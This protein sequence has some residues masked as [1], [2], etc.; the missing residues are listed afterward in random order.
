MSRAANYESERERWN[1]ASD[2]DSAQPLRCE[3]EC[4]R[5][6]LGMSRKSAGTR[7]VGFGVC[8]AGIRVRVSVLVFVNARI[9]FKDSI[10]VLVL[11][12]VK[13]LVKPREKA[14]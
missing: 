2:D 12:L 9:G 6:C 14:R 10:R 4:K 11:V 8:D 5:M 7:S 3:E 1:A 13:V